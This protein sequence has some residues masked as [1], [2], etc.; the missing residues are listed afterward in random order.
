M[1][2]LVAYTVGVGLAAAVASPALRSSKDSY[3]LSTYPMFAAKRSNPRLYVAEGVTADGSR[4]RLAPA[5][6]GTDEVMQAAVLVR[7]AVQASE[8]RAQQLCEDIAERVRRDGLASVRFIELTSA[9]YEPVA[10]FVSR[11]EPQNRVLHGRCP[12][13]EPR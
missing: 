3:P 13:H 5:L 2:R 8:Q 6:L 4:A 7:R 9:E 12:V 10:Y 1:S 11:A